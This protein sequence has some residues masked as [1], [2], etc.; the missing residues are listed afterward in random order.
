MVCFMGLQRARHDFATKQQ[1]LHTWPPDAS[2][3]APSPLTI[4]LLIHLHFIL[5]SLTKQIKTK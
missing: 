5:Y 2:F 1:E 3:H 4:S